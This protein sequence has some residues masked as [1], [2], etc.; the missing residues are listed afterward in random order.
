MDSP[1]NNEGDENKN[2]ENK[3]D[4][5]GLYTLKYI[6][7]Q[8]HPTNIFGNYKKFDIIHHWD[9]NDDNNNK[10]IPIRDCIFDMTEIGKDRIKLLKSMFN[11]WNYSKAPSSSRYHLRSVLQEIAYPIYGDS[12]IDINAL[13]SLYDK[14]VGLVLLAI[15]YMIDFHPDRAKIQDVVWMF[16]CR[17]LSNNSYDAFGKCVH[18][19]ELMSEENKL[20]LGYDNLLPYLDKHVIDTRNKLTIKQNRAGDKKSLVYFL[21]TFTGFRPG[22]ID[23]TLKELE[24]HRYLPQIRNLYDNVIGIAGSVHNINLKSAGKELDSMGAM[25]PSRRFLEL[26]NLFVEEPVIVNGICSSCWLRG[27]DKYFSKKNC[28]LHKNEN[29]NSNNHPLPSA[30]PLDQPEP[31][32]P[33]LKEDKS[34]EKEIENDD[35]KRVPAVCCICMNNGVNT[36][37]APC[38]HCYCSSCIHD[39]ETRANTSQST[40]NCPQCRT[41][42]VSIHKIFL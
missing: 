32:A 2:D 6:L 21:E 11:Y 19:K 9:N 34:E 37:V 30:P 24:R 20:C 13:N 3:N 40:F 15:I 7:S 22:D 12:S 4:E 25:C 10:Y 29:D 14:E 31:S 38:F 8:R 26:V 33:P 18:E 39:C 28:I 23:F 35:E 36:T 5:N 42:I 16:L 17:F 41:A 27:N 1:S